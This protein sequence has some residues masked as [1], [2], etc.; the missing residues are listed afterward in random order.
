MSSLIGC[1]E[2]GWEMGIT[3]VCWSGT[4]IC[5]ETHVDFGASN[6]PQV[7]SSFPFQIFFFF[8]FSSIGEFFPKLE[9]KN[10]KRKPGFETKV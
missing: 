7:G 10:R 6:P 4:E 9:Y 8:F 5:Y 2:G 1:T 3:N